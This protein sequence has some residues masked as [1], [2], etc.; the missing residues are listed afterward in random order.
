MRAAQKLRE[1][2]PFDVEELRGIAPLP[3]N[4]LPGFRAERHQC[5]V[6][7][8]AILLAACLYSGQMHIACKDKGCRLLFDLHWENWE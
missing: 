7:S 6:M 1:W 5:T 4:I 8:C 2:D 3:F